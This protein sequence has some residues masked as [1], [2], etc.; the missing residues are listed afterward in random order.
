MRPVIGPKKV[1]GVEP[2]NDP[3]PATAPVRCAGTRFSSSS[4]ATISRR[5]QW[6]AEYDLTGE[7][8]RQHQR[9]TR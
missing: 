5:V 1:S 6:Q 2:A 9:E 7:H 3:V 8:E 4:A